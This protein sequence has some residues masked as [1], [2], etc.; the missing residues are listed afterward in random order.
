MAQPDPAVARPRVVGRGHGRRRRRRERRWRGRGLDDAELLRIATTIES[1]PD[2]AAAVLLGG[3]VVSAHLGDRVEAVRF[4]APDG[5]RAVLFIPERRLSTEDMR[6]VLPGR[7]PASGRREQH[8]PG[9][10][11]GGGDRHRPARAARR[12]DRRPPPRAVPLGRLPG[13]AAPHAAPR[14]RRGRWGRSCPGPGRRCCAFVGAGRGP[15]AGRGG[16]GRCRRG[17][18]AGGAHAGRGAP[19]RGPGGD[20]PPDRQPGS[21]GLG[22]RRRRRGTNASGSGA[23]ARRRARGITPAQIGQSSSPRR[24]G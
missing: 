21:R 15:G 16:A 5:L 6:R 9:R 18:G 17:G 12:P 23:L 2:N 3:F 4:D 1:H 11:R 20:A 24:R 22:R 10:D 7:G 8:G 19:E 13:A 14:G